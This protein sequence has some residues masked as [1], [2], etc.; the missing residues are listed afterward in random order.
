MEGPE[1]Y[2]EHLTIRKLTELID[3]DKHTV[4]SWISAGLIT[5]KRGPG[6]EVQIPTVGIREYLPPPG[7][8]L[9][10]PAQ[11]M[12]QTGWSK[13]QLA[14][15]RRKGSLRSVVMPSGVN[16]YL[17]SEVTATCRRLAAAR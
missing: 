16:R 12:Q 7:D 5:V 11:V 6:N 10:S 4:S 8:A 1:P 9:I 2:P 3:V 15:A 17:D 14:Y 13:A